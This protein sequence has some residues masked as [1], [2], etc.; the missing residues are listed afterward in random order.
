M[1]DLILY[2]ANIITLDPDI[3]NAQLVAIGDGR[4]QVVAGDGALKD[5]KHSDTQVIDCC[6]KT[7]LP[8]FCDTHFHLRSS[9]AKSMSL[10]VDFGDEP[11]RVVL[12]LSEGLSFVVLNILDSIT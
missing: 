12:A 11:K 6:G 1:A 10:L 7:V 4:I 9:A 8:G 2:N 3:E 5:L